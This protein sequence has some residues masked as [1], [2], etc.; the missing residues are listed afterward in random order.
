MYA[1]FFL[2][3]LEKIA[4]QYSLKP[5]GQGGSK[6]YPQSMFWAKIRKMS[7]FLSEN[8]QV[9]EAKFSMYFNRRV[10]VLPSRVVVL[11]WRPRW[12]HMFSWRKRKILC[13]Y[14]L[15]I[16]RYGSISS[17]SMVK[18]VVVVL[19]WILFQGIKRLWQCLASL[20]PNLI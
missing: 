18:V 11:I 20:S 10:F 1:L 12:Q 4:C 9:L 14:S 13:G 6:E 17:S 16:W 2:F 8:F 15:L 19:L 3:L 7:V 5:P